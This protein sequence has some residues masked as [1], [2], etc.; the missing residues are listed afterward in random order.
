MFGLLKKGRIYMS[1]NSKYTCPCCGAALD[2]QWCFS[3]SDENWECTECGSHLY[4]EYSDEDYIVIKHICPS[5]QAPLDIQS[6]FSE[7][8][9]DWKCTECGVHLHHSYGDDEYQEVVEPKYRCPRCGAA[10]DE[11]WCFSES[12]EN[13][14][15]TECG[16]HLYHEYSD[17]DY[18][19]IKHIC[20]SCQAPLDIQSGFSEYK[21]DWKC[22]ECGAHL[23]HDLI[24]L[25]HSGGIFNRLLN[26]YLNSHPMW[27]DYTVIKHVCPNCEARLDLQPGF[28]EYNDDWKCTECGTF[29]HHSNNYEVF[30]EVD[31]PKYHCPNC[32]SS[33]DYQWMFSTDDEEWECTHCRSLL[34]YDNSDDRYI[35]VKNNDAHK[36]IS[37]E[38]KKTIEDTYDDLSKISDHLSKEADRLSKR[39]VYPLDLE[40][41]YSKSFYRSQ[42]QNNEFSSNRNSV[43]VE[44]SVQEESSNDM[45]NKKEPNPFKKMI[46]LLCITFAL[47]FI[48]VG[49]LGYR[50]YVRSVEAKNHPDEIKLTYS[51]GRYENANYYTAIKEFKNQGLSNIH[52]TPLSDLKDGF[53][54]RDDELDGIIESVEI[55]GISN[56][57]SGSWVNEESSVNI[58]YHSFEKHEKNGYEESKNN[59]LIT[60]GLDIELPSYLIEDTKN[61][62]NVTY[63]I[64]DDNQTK[65][66]I[67]TNSSEK[68]SELSRYDTYFVLEQASVNYSGM[69]GKKMTLLGEIGNEVYLIHIVTLSTKIEPEY[70]HIAIISP[71]NTKIDYS[72]DFDKILSNIYVPKSS[73]IQIDFDMKDYEGKNFEDVLKQLKSKGFKNIKVKNLEDVVIGIFA[74]EGTVDTI[75]INGS[76]EYKKGDWIDNQSEVIISYHGKK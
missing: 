29:L 70:L 54:S 56:F 13:W 20:P 7:Y 51:S 5:C 6:G 63:H 71:D 18:I 62:V 14:E 46:I 57:H 44:Q 35:I 23:H 66:L 22:T 69:S 73:E 40:D 27:E 64:E 76:T 41:S 19:V 53:F 12:D 11:Q 48:G 21:D 33:L 30:E 65:L 34:H 2:E 55:N 49:Y 26:V 45:L 67:Q 9:D 37:S 39:D 59:H 50:F 43:K 31:E 32:G 8:K 1:S 25:D 24:Q 47:L 75:S 42:E 61:E 38:T 15:C 16:S 58:I 72:S 60:S 3:E 17:E 4:H 36:L 10:L 52:L 74:K 68:W 28:S